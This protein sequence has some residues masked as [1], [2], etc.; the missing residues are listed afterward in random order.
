MTKFSIVIPVYNT[1]KYI[2]R[3]IESVKE[4]TVNDWEIILIDDGSGD[5]SPKICS[6]IAAED[7]RIRFYRQ[8]NRGQLAIRQRGVQ[9]AV[10]EYVLFLDSD[11]TW[12]PELLEKVGAVIAEFH[13]DVVIF[14]CNVI[15]EGRLLFASPKVFEDRT[16]FAENKTVLVREVLTSNS[17]NSVALKAVKRSLALDC[18]EEDSGFFSLRQGE[19]LLQV[20]KWFEKAKTVIYTDAVLYNYWRRNGSV[21]RTF[22]PEKYIDMFS[23]REAVRQFALRMGAGDEDMRLFEQALCLQI[24][25]IIEEMYMLCEKTSDVRPIVRNIYSHPFMETVLENCEAGSMKCS[26]NMKISFYLFQKQHFKLL[27]LW[28][29]SVAKLKGIKN[30][31][32]GRRTD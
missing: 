20:I 28:V 1:G 9:C 23:S 30:K 29:V 12:E 19:D 4:Q 5:D 31:L 25:R 13:S 16:V 14:R 11:D 2:L 10:G 18:I 26:V 15:M 3:C 27:E 21:S 7:S 32:R 17:L 6:E 24:I 22:C 8:E